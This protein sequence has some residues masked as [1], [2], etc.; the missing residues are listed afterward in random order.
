MILGES[1]SALFAQHSPP[2]TFD[3]LDACPVSLTKLAVQKRSGNLARVA[4]RH[5]SERKMPMTLILVMV[6]NILV[7]FAL[8]FVL[9]RIYQIRRDELERRDS[10]ALPPT[11]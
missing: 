7:A 6:F 11:A 3:E 4:W 2:W 8:G 9:G 1:D 10:L 5:W